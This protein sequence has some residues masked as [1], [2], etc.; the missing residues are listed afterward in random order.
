ME[1]VYDEKQRRI[2]PAFGFSE[3][4]LLPS[5][6]AKTF[7][8]VAMEELVWEIDSERHSD[9]KSRDVAFSCAV[10]NVHSQRMDLWGLL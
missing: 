2:N 5:D 7:E 4:F 9:G 6:G 1:R 8:N 10:V 3:K